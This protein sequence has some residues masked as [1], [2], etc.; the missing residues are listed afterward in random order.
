MAIGLGSERPF[1]ECL[2]FYLKLVAA[3]FAFA[4]AWSFFVRV[5]NRKLPPGPFSLP[6]IGN[7][8]MLGEFPHR[9]MAA[10]SLKFGP[11]MT[12]RLGSRLTL[13][14][15]SPDIAQQ[16]LK[17]HDHLFASRPPFVAAEYLWYNTTDIGFAPYGPHW[18]QMRKLCVSHLLN[19]KCFEYFRFIREEEVFS[20]IR[21]MA[22]S[23][24]P[25]DITKAVSTLVSGIMC[26][27]AFG[28]KFSDDDTFGGREIISIINES[29]LLG[30]TFNIGDYIP[31]LAWMDLQGLQRRLKN[32][33][34][35]IDILL[36][37]IIE[38]HVT[39]NDPNVKQDLLDVLLAAS[40][41]Q[42]MEPQITRDNIKAVIYDVLAA[43]TDATTTTIEWGMS[44]L[45]SNPRVLK[46]LRDELERVV[47]MERM[48]RE[49]DLP[50]LP[51]LQAV[52][53]E[54][55]RFHPPAPL[56]IPHLS[57]EDCKVLGYEIPRDT[58]VYLNVWAIG[59]NPKAWE[60]AQSFVPERFMQPGSMDE[61][62]RN[63][64]WI[65]FGAGRRRC[66]GEQLGTSVVELALGQLVH[67]FDWTLPGGITVQEVDMSETNS[68]LTVHRAQELLAVPTPRMVL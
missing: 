8:H 38:E 30:S 67:C 54:T 62:M 17:T 11:L 47:G 31:F 3:L 9:A 18:R 13:V 22:D 45:F 7:L 51:Y 27:M 57:M 23:D 15:S 55:L 63:F 53:I 42:D 21:S 29:I 37:K 50:R 32:M 28:R 34:S 6:I 56:P 20:M 59:R 26:R 60:D 40:A 48:V 41:D 12:L 49:S 2:E 14:V 66:P 10:L 5:R 19:S 35:I 24:H 61:R 64:G 43:G 36:E 58:R 65:P 44:E 39:Q 4:G 68:G 52:A 16:F 33:H 1:L 25:V 46:K